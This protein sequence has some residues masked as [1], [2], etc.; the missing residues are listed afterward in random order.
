LNRQKKIAG[1][2]LEHIKS[3]LERLEPEILTR[4]E[5]AGMQNMSTSDGRTV[6]IHRAIFVGSESGD[7][8]D[9]INALKAGGLSDLV[10][11]NYDIKKVM[12]YVREVASQHETDHALS[13]DEIKGILGPELGPALKISEKYSV[14]VNAT[15][16][17]ARG[18]K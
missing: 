11:E 13:P 7:R 4:F 17:T 2:E 12:A 15:K 6:F 9:V 16:A 3:E 5:N 14:R 10:A 1:T 18:G 8:Q